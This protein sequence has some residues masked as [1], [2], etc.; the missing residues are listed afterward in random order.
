[1][2]YFNLKKKHGACTPSIMY[3][4]T[5][6]FLTS[7]EEKISQD[8]PALTLLTPTQAKISR[9]KL[10]GASQRYLRATSIGLLLMHKT[11]YRKQW[12][13]L[14]WKEALRN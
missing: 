1:M 13:K 9:E 2:R 11:A 3:K 10:L 5:L 4:Y 14:W 12:E 8:M 7:T 6:T